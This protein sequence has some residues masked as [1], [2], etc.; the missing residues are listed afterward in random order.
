MKKIILLGCIVLT[1]LFPKDVLNII[2]FLIKE[3]YWGKILLIEIFIFSI[4]YFKTNRFRPGL[5]IYYKPMEDKGLKLTRVNEKLPQIKNIDYYREIPCNGN[6]LKVFWFLYQYNLLENETDIIGAFL[7][8][9]R[10][11]ARIQF[12][13]ENSNQ[14]I[15]L[16]NLKYSDDE[17]ENRLIDLVKK[18]S[19]KNLTIEKNEIEE[20]SQKN[21]EFEIWWKQV[22]RYQTQIFETQETVYEC[23]IGKVISEELNKEVIQ[24]LGFKKFLLNYS[25]I[26]EKTPIEVINWEEYLIFAQVMG[27][28]KEVAEQFETVYPEIED[29]RK[30]DFNY[31]SQTGFGCLIRILLYINALFLGFMITIGVNILL[32]IWRFILIGITLIK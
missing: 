26:H 19:G 21:K 4:I 28:A 27:I 25:L 8:K 2:E 23:K 30:N 7:L 24:I 10:K 3:E 11:E 9:W 5:K 29:I 32:A 13:Q 17:F 12:I 20:W 1:I 6:L 18:A 31:V 22:I 14:K 15:N 16:N